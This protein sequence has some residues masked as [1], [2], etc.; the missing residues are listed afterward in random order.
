MKSINNLLSDFVALSG[1]SSGSTVALAKTLINFGIKNV[2]SLGDFTFEKSSGTFS[3]AGTST[4]QYYPLAQN[5]NKL[6][7]VT[8][9]YGGIKYTPTEVRS[10]DTWDRLTY[11]S[12][13]TSNIP[14]FWHYKIDT[15]EVG[16]YPAIASGSLVFT[17][18]FTKK[19]K[20]FSASDYS[21]GLMTGSAGGTIF[22]GNQ[23][24]LTTG[25]T[26]R[27]IQITG[28]NTQ[29][30][31]YWFE[32]VGIKST[33]TQIFV[34]ETIP[35]AVT[36]ASYTIAEMIPLPDG[37]ESTPLWYALWQYYQMKQQ[38]VLANQYQAMY[39][40]G[41]TELE[42][43]DMATTNKLVTQELEG[44][45]SDVNTNPRTIFLE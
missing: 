30:D 23:A 1:D 24:I 33:G 43:R 10:D 40:E 32:I 18:N 28:S 44:G 25:M 39:K 41:I 45:I 13:T 11:S 21:T 26:G 20:D 29:T 7:S 12:T 38:P 37:T 4:R 22:T 42:K 34:K 31:N 9:T 15:K 16:F 19:I 17:T 6:D 3:S 8:F 27:G 36:T 14:Q 35:E 5:V 2:R